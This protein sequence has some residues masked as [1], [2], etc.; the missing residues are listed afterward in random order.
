MKSSIQSAYSETAWIVNRELFRIYLYVSH[1]HSGE[2]SEKTGTEMPEERSSL[3]LIWPLTT[4]Q[5]SS[6]P[7][8]LFTPL[9]PPCSRNRTGS[10]PCRTFAHAVL[11]GMFCYIVAWLVYWLTQDSTQMAPLQRDLPWRLTLFTL[12]PSSP[13][14]LQTF[15]LIFY[16]PTDHYLK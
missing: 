2:S 16:Q 9:P 8:C 4:S 5:P 14:S 15:A 10:L 3:H 1:R 13:V 11:W 12:P 6:F 7:F